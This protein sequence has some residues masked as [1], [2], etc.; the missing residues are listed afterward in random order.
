LIITLG[1]IH[2][3]PG[4][5]VG[6]VVGS[7]AHCFLQFFLQLVRSRLMH[8]PTERH[9]HTAHTYPL[10][11]P[12]GHARQPSAP[13]ALQSSLQG[14]HAHGRGFPYPQEN[15]R[16][17]QV[18]AAHSWNHTQTNHPTE[19]SLSLSFSLSLKGCVGGEDLEKV[20]HGFGIIGF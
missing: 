20:L 6:Q 1:V 5:V 9:L 15:A 7:V 14:V 4:Q 18:Q 13:R 12:S 3:H 19:A 11:S 16:K 17:A 8:M 2:V 10:S